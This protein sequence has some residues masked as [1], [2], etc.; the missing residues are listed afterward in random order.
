MTIDAIFSERG[1]VLT[2]RAFYRAHVLLASTH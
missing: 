1:P 2:P